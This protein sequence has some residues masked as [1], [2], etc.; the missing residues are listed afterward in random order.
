MKSYTDLEQSKKLAEFLPIE[1]ADMMWTYDFTINDIN[2]LN[3]ISDNFKPEDNDI[4]AWSLSALLDSMHILH[5][6]IG[7][8]NPFIA[9]SNKGYYVVYATMTKEWNSSDIHD[10]PIDACVEMIIKL[11]KKKLYGNDI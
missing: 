10:N 4:P 11:Y 3:V 5:T 8:A 1:S 9:K 7:E 2:G 6:D